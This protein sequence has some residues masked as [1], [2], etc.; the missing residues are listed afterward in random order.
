MVPYSVGSTFVMSAIFVAD[1]NHT[2]MMR[3]SSLS[4]FLALIVL[5]VSFDGWSELVVSSA[6]T[7][8]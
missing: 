1:F 5:V 3:I 8:P 6:P 7:M 4:S 2:L